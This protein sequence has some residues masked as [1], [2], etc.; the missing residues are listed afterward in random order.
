MPDIFNEH[1]MVS[2]PVGVLGFS[3]RVHCNCPKMLPNGVTYVELVELYMVYFDIILGMD[4]LYAFF[5]TILC[6]TR[7]VKFNF[8]TE[9]VLKW[10]GVKFYS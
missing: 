5:A 3:K 6:R 10:S 7:V 4:W 1:F 9:P 8:P 2:T